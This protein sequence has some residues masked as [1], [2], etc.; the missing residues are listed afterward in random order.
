MSE[1]D[2]PSNPFFNHPVLNSPY[3]MPSRHWELDASGQPTQRMIESRRRAQFI[4]PIP[5]PKKRKALAGQEVLVFDKGKGHS[6]RDQQYDPTSIINEVRGHVDAWRALPNSS[7]WQ[8]TP[9][10]A[11]LLMHWRTHDFSTFRPF[12]CQ[13]E[14][15]ET[16]IW[17]TEVAPQTK[18]GQRLLDHL[19]AANRDA[20]S[21]LLRVATARIEP[22]AKAESNRDSHRVCHM[23]VTSQAMTRY[24]RGTQNGVLATRRAAETTADNGPGGSVWESNPP[25]PA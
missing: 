13:V 4:T 8:V 15:A 24:S 2:S 17:L 9:E 5:N 16:M 20:S 23:V 10:T 7:H 6:T 14:A 19:V 25:R 3:V 11:R 22:D 18:S 21:G 12:F 1:N